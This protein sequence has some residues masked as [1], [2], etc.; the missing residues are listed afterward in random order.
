M[1]NLYDELKGDY[2]W[3]VHHIESFRRDVRMQRQSID[4]GAAA[5]FDK[6]YQKNMPTAQN[7]RSVKGHQS[8][9][10]ASSIYDATLF[11]DRKQSFIK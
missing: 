6:V 2:T 10:A 11:A 3:P 8:G 1:D 5:F 7:Q 4:S 9:M